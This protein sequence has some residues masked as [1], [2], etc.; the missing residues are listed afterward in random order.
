MLSAMQFKKGMRQD[1][2][3]YLA[4]LKEYDDEELSC[5]DE[6]PTEVQDVLDEFK[7]VMPNELQKKLP[8]RR[9]VDH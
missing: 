9:E 7:D 5:G 4:I 2:E 1:E 8:P 6:V 3:S